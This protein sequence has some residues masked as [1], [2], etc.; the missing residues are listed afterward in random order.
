M[1]VFFSKRCELAIKA[2]LFLSSKEAGAL[3]NAA[4]ISEIIKVPK[5]FVSKVLQILTDSGIVN[6]KKGKSGGFSL[7]KPANEIKIIEIVEAIDGKELFNQCLLGFPNC[8]EINPCPVHFDW[9]RLRKETYEILG[10]HTLAEFRDITL[11]KIS[12]L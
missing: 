8:S 11:K 2:V 7:G 1:R 3:Y 6:S 4:Q 5:E 12:S 10:R 9:A